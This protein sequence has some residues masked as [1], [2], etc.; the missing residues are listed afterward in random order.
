M[1]RKPKILPTFKT[2]EEEMRFWDEHHPADYIE[3]PSDLVI[4]L[5]PRRKRALP[6]GRPLTTS[7]LVRIL[8]EADADELTR[9]VRGKSQAKAA[10]DVLTRLALAGLCDPERDYGPLVAHLR[11][12]GANPIDV[13]KAAEM[14]EALSSL[15]RTPAP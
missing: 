14:R 11:R 7:E 8:C 1:R 3:G 12:L 9:A 2:E 13:P 10:S 6:R 15:F 5:K 4:R